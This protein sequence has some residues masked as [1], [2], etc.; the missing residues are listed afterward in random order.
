MLL[1]FG[2][3]E[4]ERSEIAEDCFWGANP[5]SDC[6]WQMTLRVIAFNVSNTPCRWMAIAGNVG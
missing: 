1:R 3:V 2:F 6:T 5:R 4:T